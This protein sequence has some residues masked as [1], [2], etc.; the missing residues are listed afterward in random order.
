MNKFSLCLA[1]WLGSICAA[2]A[3]PA[4]PCDGDRVKIDRLRIKTTA[5]PMP[6]MVIDNNISVPLIGAGTSGS[7]DWYVV[8][9][10]PNVSVKCVLMGS[11]IRAQD[12]PP[13]VS[14][15]GQPSGGDYRSAPPLD[16]PAK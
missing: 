4:P 10:V 8:W 7:D 12:L 13:V 15:P 16:I 14:N 2:Q 5:N 3:Q 11:M 6:T 9:N 1:L